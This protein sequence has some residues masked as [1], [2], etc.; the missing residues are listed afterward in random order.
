MKKI[1]TFLMLIPLFAFCI[2]PSS[3]KITGNIAGIEGTVYLA[4]SIQG[5][6]IIIDSTNLNNGKFLFEG[7]VKEPKQCFLTFKNN[8]RA[9][10]SFIVEN[11]KINIQA[12]IKRVS[13]AKITGSA[14]QNIMNDYNK[15][16]RPLK[17]KRGRLLSD[18]RKISKDGD[19]K[20]KQELYTQKKQLENEIKLVSEKFVRDNNKSYAALLIASELLR[21]E[22][23][24]ARIDEMVA[25]LDAS[26]E[27]K[28]LLIEMKRISR[29]LKN[30]VIGEIAPDFVMN[31]TERKPVKLS[32]LFGK[33]YL[34]I[35]FWASWCSPC[36]SENPY[37]LAAYKKYHEKGFEV[38]GVSYDNNK[39]KWLKAIEEDQLP[40]L[41][42]SDLKGWNSLTKTLYAISGI[43]SNFL[44][45]KNG[46]IIAKN[47]RGKSLHEKLKEIFENE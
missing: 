2:Q 38:L 22:K 46:K 40:W 26:F 24:P 30:T 47:L 16:V 21:K 27:N 15:I 35:D 33:G 41:H 37:V 39:E 3:Y 32:S 12:D 8:K 25:L 44:L 28:Y 18:I 20:K 4:Q 11:S 23:N 36:R 17:G 9:Y 14:S 34:L 13:L 7:F 5:K 29:S 45:D 6:R 43:P 19:Q 1:F 31:D 42:V 10:I